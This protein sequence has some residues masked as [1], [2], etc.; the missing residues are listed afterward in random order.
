MLGA[1]ALVLDKEGRSVTLYIT[2]TIACVFCTD[3]RKFQGASSLSGD[4]L[5]YNDKGYSL[6][7]RMMT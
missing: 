6:S 2:G 3:Y 5:S 4:T 7:L 1:H